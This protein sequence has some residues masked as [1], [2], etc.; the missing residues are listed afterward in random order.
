MD[1]LSA[2]FGGRDKLRTFYRADADSAEPIAAVP[3]EIITKIWKRLNA[4]KAQPGWLTDLRNLIGERI[5]AGSEAWTLVA[6]AVPHD[7]EPGAQLSPSAS[8]KEQI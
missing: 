4:G 7:P 3:I 1:G 6:V 2:K 5:G 8:A